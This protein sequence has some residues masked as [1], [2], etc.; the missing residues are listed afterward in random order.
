MLNMTG[1]ENVCATAEEIANGEGTEAV[2]CAPT[3][4]PASEIEIGGIL[5]NGVQ[6][7]AVALS[8]GTSVPLAVT[9]NVFVAD[10]PR[11]GPLP[12][13][14]EWQS[15]DGKQHTASA[16]LPSGVATERCAKS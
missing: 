10:F 8:N 5:P 11:N 2:L 9:G 14:I 13:A 16:Q 7:T 6:D 1:T 15:A 4:L 12:V 3:S